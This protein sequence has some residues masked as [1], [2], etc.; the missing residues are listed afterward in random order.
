MKIHIKYILLTL[1][2]HFISCNDVI[3]VDVPTATPRLVIEAS[4]DWEKGTVGNEQTIKLSNTKPYFDI[5][6]SNIVAGA[7]VKVTNDNDSTEF[8]FIDQNNGE[9]TTTSFVP[10]LN[11]SYTLEVIYNNETYNAQE[12]LMPVSSIINIAQSYEGG[13]DD[14]VLDVSIYFQDPPDEDNFYLVRFKE[15]GDLFAELEDLS[16]EF[17][18]GNLIDTWFEKEDND[19]TNEESFIPGDIVNIDLHGIS[20]R[21]HNYI[22]LLIEQSNSGGDPF[23]AVP[24]ALKG[25]CINHIQPDNYALGYFRLTEVAKVSYTFQ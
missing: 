20:E 13:F 8:I 15:V 2:I 10:V 22:R 23:S 9:Y 14:E 25:N 21:Y 5:A 17:V 7:S 24:A 11:Q 16:D 12:T 3:D 18:N 6:T 4:L 1:S 19:D